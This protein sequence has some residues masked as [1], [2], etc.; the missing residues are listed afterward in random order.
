VFKQAVES[1]IGRR[2]LG[3]GDR[4]EPWTVVSALFASMF[5]DHT[6]EWLSRRVLSDLGSARPGRGNHYGRKCADRTAA[7]RRLFSVSVRQL[8]GCICV[9]EPDPSDLMRPP[10]RTDADVADLDAGQH[11]DPSIVEPIEL[12]AVWDP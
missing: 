3:R 8:V 5:D 10:G 2:P 12:V 6:I 7:V 9:G 11:D 1:A 4:A